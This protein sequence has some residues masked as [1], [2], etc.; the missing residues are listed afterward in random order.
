MNVIM[1]AQC[2]VILVLWLTVQ[3]QA[4]PLVYI[5]GEGTQFDHSHSNPLLHLP[6]VG[7]YLEDLGPTQDL[8]LFPAILHPETDIGQVEEPPATSQCHQWNPRGTCSK[9]HIGQTGRMLEHRMKEHKRALALGNIALIL[10]KESWWWW[11][12]KEEKAFCKSKESLTSSK[13]L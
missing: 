8:Y 6:L 12:A 4:C 1:H 9:V 3:L 11:T 7:D 13:L 2:M 10:R 5:H